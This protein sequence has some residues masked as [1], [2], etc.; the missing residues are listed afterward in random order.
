MHSLG[1]PYGSPFP[2][3]HNSSAPRAVSPC[4][5]FPLPKG[6]IDDHGALEGAIG[7]HCGTLRMM[8]AVAEDCKYILKT[9]PRGALCLGACSYFAFFLA[10]VISKL[11]FTRNCTTSSGVSGKSTEI[12]CSLFM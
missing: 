1:L 2:V 8:F 6:F 9:Q 10:R 7:I 4:C 12:Q 3:L 11:A 5:L